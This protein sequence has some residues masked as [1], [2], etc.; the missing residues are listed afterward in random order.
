MMQQMQRGRQG[1][2]PGAGPGGAGPPGAG[3]GPG[4]QRGL[5]QQG[6]PGGPGG[7]GG[8]TGGP[9]DFKTPQ[10]AVN[11]FLNA[12]KA[13]DAEALKEATAQHAA[14][15]SAPGNQKM[16]Q[17]ILDKSLPD[18]ELSDLAQKLEGYSVS[19][20]NP[21]KSTG[22]AEVIIAK[23][24]GR[25]RLTRKITVRRE[26]EGWKVEDIAGEREFRSIGIGTKRR[27]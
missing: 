17:N 15:E 18:D 26:K 6:P 19:S 13:K 14:T 23:T 10:G 27:R 21:P 4:G 22:R 1:G 16:F 9:A 24:E 20:M 2:P 8:A 3:G 7:P 12:L 11:A 25:V 5:G